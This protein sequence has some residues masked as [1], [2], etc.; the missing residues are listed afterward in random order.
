[1]RRRFRVFEVSA[2]LVAAVALLTHGA[3]IN[4]SAS[5]E[6]PAHRTSSVTYDRAAWLAD[7]RFGV[8]NHYLAD[9]IARREQVPGAR[10]TPEQWNELLDRFDVERHAEQVAATGARYQIFTIGQNSGFYCSPNATY[11]RIVGISPSHCSRRDLI[12]D[13]ADALHRRGLRLIVYLPAGAPS[14]D[15]EARERLQWQNGA[16]PNKEFQRNWEAIIREWSMRWGRR[17]DGWWYDGCYWPNTMYRSDEPPNFKS[18][19][20]ASRAGNPD[21]IVAFNPGVVYRTISLTPHEDYTAG[22]VDKPELWLPRRFADGNQ[23]GARLHML[24]F[25]GARWG[26]GDAPRF[27]DEDAITWSRRVI[28]A[29]G[30]VTWDVPIQRDGTM[31]Q[32]FLDQL[33]AIGHAARVPRPT[34]APATTRAIPSPARD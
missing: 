12:A 1:M 26:T 20:D 4:R 27:K 22:E 13:L 2:L 3:C 23:D 9:W 14:Q 19:A 31:A 21:A 33:T 15:S 24:S 30:A 10:F 7:A 5:T 28:D 6:T 11:D 29:G 8:M 32:S 16:Q 34:S 18:F 17:V 25:L